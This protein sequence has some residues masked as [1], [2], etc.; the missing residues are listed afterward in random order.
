MVIRWLKVQEYIE[1][2]K[3]LKG[4]GYLIEGGRLIILGKYKLMQILRCWGQTQFFI[5][6]H[7]GTSFGRVFNLFPS[8]FQTS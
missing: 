5:G 2:S 7:R 4:R 8:S 1:Y 3:C 6:T